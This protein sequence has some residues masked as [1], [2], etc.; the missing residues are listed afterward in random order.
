M[1]AERIG[2]SDSIQ[3]I[4]TFEVSMVFVDSNRNKI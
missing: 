4:G 2:A 1:R 3:V